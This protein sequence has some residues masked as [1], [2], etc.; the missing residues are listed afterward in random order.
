MHR[1]KIVYLLT[2]VC[3]V[4]LTLCCISGCGRKPKTVVLRYAAW[5]LG[6]AAQNGLERRM[7][8]EFM[9]LHPH[10]RIK[11]D[12]AFVKNYNKALSSAA[13]A[14]TIPDVFMYAGNPQADENG[15]CRDVT[16]LAEK[17]PEW[18]NI[19]KVL[20]DSA[21]VKGKIIAIPTAMYFYG[22]F[23][24]EK[25]FDESV[26]STPKVGFSVKDYISD[27]K[28]ATDI[29][30][31]RIGLADESSIGDWYP[32]AVE[33]SYGWYTWDGG[34]FNLDSKA[35]IEGVQLA[36]FFSV[37]HY[38]Y[39][40]LSAAQKKKLHGN[41]DWEAWNA[42]TVAMKFDGTWA[43]SNYG[44]LSFPVSFAG[45]PGGRTCIVPDYLFISKNTVH[46]EEAYEFVKFMSAYSVQGFSA[47]LKL[48]KENGFEVDTMPMVKD[49]KLL[50]EYF[51]R[52]GMKGIREAYDRLGSRS[53]V[54]ETKVLPGYTMARWNYITNLTAG[55]KKN[56]SIGE[57]LQA[58]ERGGIRIED[59]AAHLNY[60]ANTCIQIYPQQLNN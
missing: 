55:K 47:R 42:G 53:F 14:N 45:I 5:N 10:I 17:D 54:E 46:P 39:A 3:M 11:M 25:L 21:R 56:A 49:Q 40:L 30:K 24:N 58:A 43:A 6:T 8:A 31:G 32:A 13:A 26:K 2:L 51:S 23:C 27:V 36:N 48:A 29:E 50:N 35:F 15:W 9:R 57:V 52:L 28:A 20:Q 59:V 1:M 18:N 7:V 38:C 34:K 22:Y 12:E 37:N 19:P 41:N 44:K 60:L 16:L 33:S 4:V